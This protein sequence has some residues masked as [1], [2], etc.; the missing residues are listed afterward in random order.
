MV[1]HSRLNKMHLKTHFLVPYY[2][3]MPAYFSED[4]LWEIGAVIIS[5]IKA[6]SL[7]KEFVLPLQAFFRNYYSKYVN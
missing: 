4:F 3:K 1:K 7:L 2:T 6:K 5:L